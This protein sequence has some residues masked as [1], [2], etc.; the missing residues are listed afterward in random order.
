MAKVA[1][2]AVLIAPIKFNLTKQRFDLIEI[3]IR[4][5]AITKQNKQYRDI[6]FI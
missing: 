4:Q 6:T 1:Q 5:I 3:P 2:S